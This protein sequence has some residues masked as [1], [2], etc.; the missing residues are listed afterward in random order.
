M[1]QA[2]PLDSNEC[3]QQAFL[4]VTAAIPVVGS[5]RRL[6][7]LQATPPQRSVTRTD[8]CP[9][10]EGK[11]FPQG[12]TQCSLSVEKMF[13]YEPLKACFQAIVLSA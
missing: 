1:A 5:T 13:S 8:V 11:K 4:G 10:G 12:K 3:S 7:C 6:G 9:M 2:I